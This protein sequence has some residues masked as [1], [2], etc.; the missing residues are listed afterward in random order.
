[1]F[2]TGGKD[3][4]L[5]RE[6][7]SRIGNGRMNGVGGQMRVSIRQFLDCGAFRQLPENEFDRDTST[8]DRWL[9]KHHS[10]VDA[11]MVLHI[12]ATMGAGILFECK[13]K[14]GTHR[15]R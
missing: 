13:M 4:F 12:H 6:C 10:R 2:M 8:P 5:M 15:G 14:K 7:V 1:M 11:N 9:A 3:K